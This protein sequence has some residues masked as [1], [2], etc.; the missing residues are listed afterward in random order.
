MSQNSDP[1]NTLVIGKVQPTAQWLAAASLLVGVFLIINGA[2]LTGACV[3]IWDAWSFYTPAFSLVA[4]HARAGRLLRW[5]P[6]LAGGTPDF[7]DPQVGA[8]SPIA[9]IIGAI[10]GGTG[11]AF[12]A[13]WLFIWLLGPLGL[14]LLARHLGAS[15]WGAFLVSVGYAFCGF[16]TAHA[17]HTTV[18]YSFSFVPWFIWRFDV[19]LTSV[20]FRPAAQAGALW[21]L[22]ALGGYPAIVILSGGMM[23]LWGLGR[24]LCRSNEAAQIYERPIRHR[25]EF[26]FLALV[27]AFAVGVVILAPTYVAFFKEGLGY[28]ERAGAMPRQAAI[29]AMRNALNPGAL[30]TFA[31]PYL[32]TLKFPYLNPSLWKGSD[33]SVADVYIGVLPL[34]LSLLA[35]WQRPRSGWRWWLVGI[36]A[37]SLACAVG[38]R[39]PVR[40]W[41]YDYCPPTRYFTHPGM[42]RGYAIFS[43]AVL[44][45]LG[46]RD[47]AAAARKAETR[48]WRQL[49]L[50]SLVI[51]IAAVYAYRYVIHQVADSGTKLTLSNW[52]L[53][54]TWF[55]AV[56]LS[57]LLL[58]WRRARE[59]FAVLLLPLAIL[60]ATLT[61][62]LSQKFVCD[63]RRTRSLLMRA[64]AGHKATLSVSGLQRE[65]QPSPGLG[66][67]HSNNTLTLRIATFYNDSTM[68]NRFHYEFAEHPV[69]LNMGL[70][71]D[72]IWFAKDVAIVLPSH[73]AYVALANRS[74][75]L[76]VPAITVHPAA[77]MA[78]V[79]QITSPAIPDRAE[80][81]AISHLPPA[82]KIYAQV[83]KYTP[84]D[85]TLKVSCPEN[86]WLIVT[87]RWAAGW[88]ARVN[89]V[90]EEVFGANFIFRAVR[91]RAGENTIQFYY[92]QPLYFTLLLLSWTTLVVVFAMPGWKGWKSRKARPAA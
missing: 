34:I 62:Q 4:D 33:I 76:G 52:H 18:L 1:R 3:Q 24:C 19:A 41:L 85:L 81:T 75:Q 68:K 49:V 14:L 66:G 23:F 36:I 50:I 32:T 12:R 56:G 79:S 82:Q 84:N 61:L 72:R 31:S 29:G 44:A 65:L 67:S 53:V 42:F 20:R 89:G 21:G 13:Y 74:Q 37:F 46:T 63:S 48:I 43:A 60:D 92:P 6:W 47:L 28:T 59:W 40:G 83:L 55:G 30:A 7:A 38:D 25:L 57:L 87:D 15:P 69:L 58:L 27:V 26:T 54:A 11:A 86:G 51:S 78:K 17:E 45:L 88:R 35:I 70:G 16:Y 91:V 90:P 9:I 5:D 80:L 71:A 22:S 8:A 10:G 39:L 2:L 77:Q 64:D 73:L